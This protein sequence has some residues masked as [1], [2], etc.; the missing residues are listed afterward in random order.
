MEDADLYVMVILQWNGRYGEI[1][2]G[3]LDLHVSGQ[4]PVVSS[5]DSNKTSNTVI[6][7]NFKN[8]IRISAI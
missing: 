1:G 2:S 6:G 7:R 4:V 8:E 5:C 3:L